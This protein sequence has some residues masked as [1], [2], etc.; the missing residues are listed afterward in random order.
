MKEL[1]DRVRQTARKL[2]DGQQ[3]DLVLGWE[4]GPEPFRSQPVFIRE[5][6]EAE[7]LVF[8]EFCIHNLSTFLLDYRDGQEKI[9]IF[10]KGCDSRGVVRLIEDNQFLR[11]RLYII[12]IGCPGM[13]DPLA[14]ARAASGLNGT[15]ENEGL[16]AKCRECMYPNPVL[17][18]ELIGDEQPPHL[19]GE[20]FAQV[21]KLE[22]MSAEERWQFFSDMFSRCIRCYACR[23]VCVACNCRRCIFDETRPQWVGRETNLMDNIGYHVI[24]AMH[25]A[26]RCVECGECERVCPVGIPLMLLNRKLI[27]DVNELFGPY[28]ASLKLEEEASPPLSVYR[29]DDP[30]NFL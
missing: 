24:R 23:N 12:G 29:P 20:R 10:V 21:K 8:D 5:P 17:Y 1:T 26:G 4:K 7:Q 19:E 11:E 3:V 30:D 2:L 18:D 16:A 27:K 22:G 13:K 14:A 6:E 15:E 25:V 9:G 28:E